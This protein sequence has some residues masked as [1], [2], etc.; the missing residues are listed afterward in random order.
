MS[1]EDKGD[2]DSGIGD[3]IKKV[4]SIGI[5]AAFMTEDAVRT[6]LNDLPLPKQIVSGLIQNA[7][8]AKEEF[9]GNV[10]EELKG[11]FSKIDPSSLI[12]ELVENYDIEIN[13]KLNFTRKGPKKTKKKKS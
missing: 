11:H 6:V 7:Q 8:S 1:K 4:V 5:G 10:R 3:V 9:I 13:A 2:K 12:Q